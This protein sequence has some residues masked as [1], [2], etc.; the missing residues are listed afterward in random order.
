ME[1]LQRQRQKETIK[2]SGGYYARGF[3]YGELGA[4]C[5][6]G[7]IKIPKGTPQFI[8]DWDT[9][10]LAYAIYK[11]SQGVTPDQLL[12]SWGTHE[13]HWDWFKSAMKKAQVILHA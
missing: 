4:L 10:T 12:F 3:D 13:R 11:E 1:S 6:Q 2:H 9:I 7:K 8:D 5:S